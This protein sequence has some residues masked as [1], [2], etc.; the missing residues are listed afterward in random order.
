MSEIGERSF[1]LLRMI[2]L[3]LSVCIYIFFYFEKNTKVS[4]RICCTK[5][6]GLFTDYLEFFPQFSCLHFHLNF[7][8]LPLHLQSLCV[9]V[10][11]R[12]KE[13]IIV[14]MRRGS[15]MLLISFS[16]HTKKKKIFFSFFP[17][18]VQRAEKERRKKEVKLNL[19]RV[20]W[21][22][23]SGELN[24]RG[25]FFLVL[26]YLFGYQ[27]RDIFPLIATDC[28]ESYPTPSVRG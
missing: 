19:R 11:M 17:F 15:K 1:S 4:S 13:K 6:I 2:K 28:V 21:S 18:Q 5:L 12:K 20:W 25:I 8:L 10:P 26:F 14:D 23:A 24:R 27:L 16:A 9:V 7:V 3:Q 22:M